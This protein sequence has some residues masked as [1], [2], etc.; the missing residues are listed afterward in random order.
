MS[1]SGQFPFCK[2]GALAAL[3]VVVQG[4]GGGGS[5]GGDGGNLPA[6][7]GSTAAP[8]VSTPSNYEQ[9]RESVLQLLNTWRTTC[10]WRA[11][12][13]DNLLDSAAQAHADYLRVARDVSHFEENKQNPYY[14]GRTLSERANASGYS[15]RRVTE[16][17]AGANSGSYYNRAGANDGPVKMDAN[18]SPATKHLKRLFSAVYHMQGVLSDDVHVGIGFSG[19]GNISNTSSYDLYWDVLS[20]NTATPRA[21]P[22]P[23]FEGVRSFPCDGVND[24]IP[25]FYPENPNPKPGNDQFAN[26]LG[27]PVM[28]QSSTGGELQVSQATFTTESGAAVAFDVLTASNDPNQMLESNEAFLMPTKPLQDNTR[29]LVTVQGRDS[30]TGAFTRSFAFRTGTQ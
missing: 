6:S 4:C 21:Q 27:H 10:G 2:W 23:T 17:V 28:L 30:V 20:I 14:T 13:S 8:A 11:L 22:L 19:T 7:T 12:S 9:Q 1:A 26:P 15:W 25:I 24:V 5:D 29:Y 16:V 3:L 18:H